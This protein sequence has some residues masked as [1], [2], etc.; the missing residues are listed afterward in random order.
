MVDYRLSLVFGGLT[1]IIHKDFLPDKLM[2]KREGGGVQK[3]DTGAGTNSFCD[4]HKQRKTRGGSICFL[5]GASKT[6]FYH[7]IQ[8]YVIFIRHN[9][10]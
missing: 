8:L 7:L 1:P 2:L 5:G 10:A 9:T 3:V 4:V 6:G